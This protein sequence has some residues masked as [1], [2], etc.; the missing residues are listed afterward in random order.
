M[1]TRRP[2]A[3]RTRTVIAP[4]LPVGSTQLAW[5]MLV[6]LGALALGSFMH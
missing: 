1:R 3:E 2:L 4:W 6:V 5:L